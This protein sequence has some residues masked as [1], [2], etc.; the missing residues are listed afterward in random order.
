MLSPMLRHRAMLS[1]TLWPALRVLLLP[2][3]SPKLCCTIA[4]AL[5][6]VLHEQTADAINQGSLSL[7]AQCRFEECLRHAIGF[8]E[9]SVETVVRQHRI[10]AF[11][12]RCY[13]RE[14]P[15]MMGTYDQVE[16]VSYLV[17]VRI[18]YWH[19]QRLL[20][21]NPL[22]HQAAVYGLSPDT[23]TN[24]C[25]DQI[26]EPLR[27]FVE[28]PTLSLGVKLTRLPI[29]AERFEDYWRNWH[30]LDYLVYGQ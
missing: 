29:L 19:Q 17:N 13:L 18:S 10:I 14:H 23:L 24:F 9:R 15:M 7:L 6:V 5:F 28:D 8:T 21:G 12:I 20:N 16:Q 2:A 4:C 26:C 27:H 3:L 25:L 1:G 22:A 30:R 11:K